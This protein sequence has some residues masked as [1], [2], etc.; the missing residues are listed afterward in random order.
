RNAEV[1]RAM[2]MLPSLLER[3]RT[4]NEAVMRDTLS[5]S[6]LSAA[7]LGITKA[8]R[9][10]VQSVTLGLGAYLVLQ[11]EASGG[12]MIAASILLGRALAPIEMVMGG[13]RN[14]TT[15]RLAYARLRS[16]LQSVP[17][18]PPRTRLP[19]PYGHVTLEKVSY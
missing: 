17:G 19:E 8:V 16:R 2:G 11:G 7:I 4:G 12:V 18:E 6:H 3:W 5:S 15:T 13:W 1:V 10:F 9:F 14:F